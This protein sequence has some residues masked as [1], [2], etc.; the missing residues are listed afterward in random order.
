MVVFLAS[1][2]RSL[3]AFEIE[4]VLGTPI[5][6]SVYST[7]IYSLINSSPVNYGSATALSMFI[8]VVAMPLVLL[9]FWITRRRNYTTVS[10]HTRLARL[11]Q[12]RPSPSPISISTGW[13]RP[14]GGHVTPACRRS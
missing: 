12:R 5:Q 6:F 1:L 2:I 8:L 9:Q 14:G 4:L 11:P 3:E 13:G 7:K 10:A